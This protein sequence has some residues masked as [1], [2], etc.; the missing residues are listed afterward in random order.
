MDDNF[1]NGNFSNG[2]GNSDN[3]YNAPDA[4]TEKG[5]SEEQKTDNYGSTG[6]YNRGQNNTNNGASS[7]GYYG[8]SPNQ[9]SGQNYGPTQNYGYS[10]GGYRQDS[11]PYST[12][13]NQNGYNG[14]NYNSPY[15]NVPP[16]YS[17]PPHGAP[18]NNNNSKKSPGKAI[19]A[20]IIAVCVVIA[21]I[22]IGSALKGNNAENKSNNVTEENKEKNSVAPAL[23]SKDDEAEDETESSGGL[24]KEAIYEK[25][26]NINVGVKVYSNSQQTGEGSGIISACDDTYTYIITCAHVISSNNDVQ[27]E[28]FDGTEI[29]AEIVG[30]DTKTDVG[31]LKIKKTGL[32]IATFADS[33]KLKVG[34]AVYAIGNPGGSEFF[35]TFTNG[36]VTAIDRPV[37]TSNS[38][39]DLP[40]IQHNAAI[41]PG[42][43]GGA[44]VNSR[45]EVVGLNSSKIASTEYEGMGFSVPVNTVKEIYKD[46]AAH[47][48]VTNRPKLGIT[49]YAVSSNYTY[50]AIAWKNNLPYGSI[51]IQ[52]I[53]SDSS[54]SNTDV[55][56]GDIITSVN[57]KKLESTDILLDIIEKSNVGDTL[58][59]GVC[60]LNNNGS[61]NKT[62]TVKV[63]LVEDKGNT[64]TE[65]PT[66]ESGMEGFEYYFP[67]GY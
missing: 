54:F 37:S 11:N 20:V 41:N 8:T 34:N 59:I 3:G 6:Y 51:V 14:Q 43:S 62:F 1:N 49:Y 24:T 19:F 40:C 36:M 50:S 13:P 66:T 44:L 56:S 57:G 15:G 48:Y 58:T 23:N 26:K 18:N 28:F 63:K 27:I 29:D 32:E 5:S 9:S 2:N 4:N 16:Q 64:V 45:G 33:D 7:S 21:F 55:K 53:S 38:A 47:G 12:S 30:Y 22:G 61:L 35:G 46:I 39:Y 67:F 42:N 65:Q 52:E 31:V 25:V 60:R 10:Q 17:Q